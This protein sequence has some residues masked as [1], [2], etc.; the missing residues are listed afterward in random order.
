VVSWG[1]HRKDTKSLG[2]DVKKCG[3]V[4]TDT[5]LGDGGGARNYISGFEGSQVVLV[6]MVEVIHMI[7][8][9]FI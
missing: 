2:R 9:I 3:E 4:V 1:I 6:L 5:T 8:I 7:G